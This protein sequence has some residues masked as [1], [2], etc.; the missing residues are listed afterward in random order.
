MTEDTPRSDS[1]SPSAETVFDALGHRHRRAVVR[2]LRERDRDE[3]VG[4]EDLAASVAAAERGVDPGDVD[5]DAL[6]S[7][8]TTL[9]H[10]HLPRLDD[11]GA[12]SYDAE[13]GTV[14]PARIGPFLDGIDSAD[15]HAA[16]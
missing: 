9:Y 14:R 11:A 7:A 1:G 10:A 2:E 6:E 15:D 8:L 3:A 13:A 4:L 5:P 12:I 16:D